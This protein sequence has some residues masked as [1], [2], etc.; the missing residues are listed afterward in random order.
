[1][2][3]NM[4]IIPFSLWDILYTTLFYTMYELS[5][6]DT[7]TLEKSLKLEIVL[8]TGNTYRICPG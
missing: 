8:Y 2:Y 1:M 4:T 5:Q 7:F 3:F 6:N